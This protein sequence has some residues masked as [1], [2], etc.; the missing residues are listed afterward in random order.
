M[1]EHVRI[2]G[3]RHHSPA[4]ARLVDEVLSTFQPDW[5]LIEG[6]SD[7]NGRLEELALDHQPPVALFSFHFSEDR[8]YSAWYPFCVHSPEWIALRFGLSGGAQVRFI[9]LPGWA[10]QE[11]DCENRYAD[12]RGS[13]DYV[14]ELERKTGEF[15]YDAVWDA[16]FELPDLT[17]LEDRL[18]AYFE[19]LR[20]LEPARA[21]DLARES[22]MGDYVAWAAKQG[23]RVLVVCG[24]YHAPVLRQA[25]GQVIET[26]P[27][28]PDPPAEARAE[29]WLVPYSQKRLDSFA[30]YASGLPSPAWYRWSWESDSPARLGLHATAERLRRRGLNIS[31]ADTVAAWTQA[32]TLSRL[33]GHQTVARVDL[34]DGVASTWIK[35]ALSQ[36]FPWSTRDMLQAETHP[37]M[38]ELVAALSGSRRG[39]L[40]PKTPLPPLF[41]R[42]EETLD[43]LDLRPPPKGARERKLFR[44]EPQDKP[45]IYALERLLLLDIPGFKRITKPEASPQVFSITRDEDYESALVEAAS[46]GP[47]LETAT[48][49]CLEER[50][51]HTVGLVPLVAVLADAVRANLPSLS[52]RAVTTLG[53]V[54]QAERSFEAL[55]QGLAEL[56][57]LLRHAGLSPSDEKTARTLTEAAVDRGLWLAE[58]IRGEGPLS[59]DRVVAVMAM[60]DAVLLMRGELQVPAARIGGVWRRIALSPDVPAD[61]QGAALGSLVSLNDLDARSGAELATSTFESVSATLLGD[62][63]V[64]LLSL[65]REV[66]TAHEGLMFGLDRALSELDATEFKLALPSLRLAFQRLPSRERASLAARITSIHGGTAHQLTARLTTSAHELALASELENQTNRLLQEYGFDD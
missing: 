32:E 59:T 1:A 16:C 62:Y 12:R 41:H 42:V 17:G 52:E 54:I 23:G 18:G 48:T 27:R 22:F 50:A 53:Q 3:V 33:R 36:P 57:G 47:T 37:V 45:T 28:P 31:V 8:R 20:G 64:G 4:C 56:G 66:L 30:G 34:L 61:L 25:I 13:P 51:A 63:L 49:A 39:A 58:G 40:A 29:T 15:G 9:D 55:G 19:G 5:I 43:T 11:G 24:G 60:R 46:Y 6:P 14:R 38:V 2:V 7:M 65:A 44:G 21:S 26:E 10:A 35:E